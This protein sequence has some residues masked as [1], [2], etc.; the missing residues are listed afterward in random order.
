MKKLK[1]ASILFFV[2]A[3]SCL[4]GDPADMTSENF[5]AA[6]GKAIASQDWDN[7]TPLMHA[8][9]SVTFSDGS[10]HQ[11][12]KE[13]EVAFRR[14]FSLIQDEKYA[15]SNVNWIVKTD[16]FAVFTFVYEW[17]GTIAGKPARGIGRGTSSLIKKN[18]TW[19]LT[20]EHLGPKGPN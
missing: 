14:N 6:Y 10:L 3:V 2:F 9:C 7:V 16:G 5:V 18:E 1:S 13:V 12:K 20:S 8:N 15:I 4:A 11:G 19:L 17:S